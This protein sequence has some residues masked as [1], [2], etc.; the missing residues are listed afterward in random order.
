MYQEKGEIN[1]LELIKMQRSI[2]IQ[3]YNLCN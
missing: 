3:E 2:K 1:N